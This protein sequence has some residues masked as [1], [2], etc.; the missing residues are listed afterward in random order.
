MHN[1]SGK[2]VLV[3][4]DDEF[5]REI[6]RKNLLYL[7]VADIYSACDGVAGIRVLN[8]MQQLPDFVICDIF[9]PDMDGIEF[10]GEL[11]RRE[12]Q[13]GIILMTGVSR[14]ML[15]VAQEIASFKGLKMLG[16]CTKPLQY[17]A[18]SSMMGLSCGKDEL[19]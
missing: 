7:G 15:Q 2:S 9:M 8:S 13:G 14:D 17:E 5:S 18:L 11:A 6:L 16:A 12:Y 10:L 3:V 19:S 1:S 4:E